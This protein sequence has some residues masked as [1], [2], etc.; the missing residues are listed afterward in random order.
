MLLLTIA[1]LVL[2]SKMAKLRDTRDCL[3]SSFD[4]NMIDDEEFNILNDMNSSKNP[5]FPYWQYEP[6]DLDCLSDGECKTEFRF[7]K[8]YIYLLKEVMPLPDEIICYN[9]LILVEFRYFVFC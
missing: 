7:C 9:R 5:D 6:F 4:R 3:L 8:N 1:V 2:S